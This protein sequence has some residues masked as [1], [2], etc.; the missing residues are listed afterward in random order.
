[1]PAG[2][3]TPSGLWLQGER[4]DFILHVAGTSRWHRV[5]ITFATSI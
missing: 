4:R 5:A 2:I 1:M 3:V